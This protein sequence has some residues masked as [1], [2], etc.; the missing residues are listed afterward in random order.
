MTDE[1]EQLLEQTIEFKTIHNRSQRRKRFKHYIEKYKEHMSMLENI[2]QLNETDEDYEKKAIMR[3]DFLKKHITHANVLRNYIYSFRPKS[4]NLEKIQF[5]N[6][7]I[8]Y[9]GKEI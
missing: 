6:F 4:M 8:Y 5:N 3:F 2:K 9:D 1:T 7:T